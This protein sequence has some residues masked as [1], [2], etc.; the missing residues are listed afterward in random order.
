MNKNT[1]CYCIPNLLK[2]VH[3]VPLCGWLLASAIILPIN[4]VV[5][6][7]FLMFQLDYLLGVLSTLVLLMLFRKGNIYF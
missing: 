2:L 7:S 1:L 3:Q 4:F 5:H 6:Y